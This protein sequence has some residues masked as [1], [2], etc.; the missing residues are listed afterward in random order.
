MSKPI[1]GF[2]TPVFSARSCSD[3]KTHSQQRW[4]IIVLLFAFTV[5]VHPCLA[6][7][8]LADFDV[9][10]FKWNTGETASD[11]ALGISAS[12]A[13]VLEGGLNLM[14]YG[15]TTPVYITEGPVNGAL[16]YF[17]YVDAANWT[18]ANGD[19]NDLGVSFNSLG[20][21]VY[22]KVDGSGNLEVISAPDFSAGIVLFATSVSL[23]PNK[24]FFFEILNGIVYLFY[25]GTLLVEHPLGAAGG[26]A[27]PASLGDDFVISVTTSAGGDTGSAT[28]NNLAR[29]PKLRVTWFPRVLEP[30]LNQV[31][32]SMGRD[33]LDTSETVD[34]A[35]YLT[36][37]GSSSADNVQ[38]QLVPPLGVGI[39]L[40]GAASQDYGSI[41]SGASTV[42][43]FRVTTAATPVGVHELTLNVTGGLSQTLTTSVPVWDLGATITNLPTGEA[44]ITGDSPYAEHTVDITAPEQIID[45]DEPYTF[46]LTQLDHRVVQSEP[47]Y[48]LHWGDPKVGDLDFVAKSMAEKQTT[49]TLEVEVNTRSGSPVPG[50]IIEVES[51]S[52]T[53]EFNYTGGDGKITFSGLEV[54]DNPHTVTIKPPAFLAGVYGT[55]T[56]S[57]SPEPGSWRVVATYPDIPASSAPGGNK[58]PGNAQ[59]QN[60]G[61]GAGTPAPARPAGGGKLKKG[62][63]AASGLLTAIGTGLIDLAASPSGPGAVAASVI[64]AGLLGGG[65]AVAADPDDQD[66]FYIGQTATPPVDPDE[67]T[68]EESVEITTSISPAIGPRQES[69]IM[70]NYT[71]TRITDLDTYTSSGSESLTFDFFLPLTLQT[72]A[73][74]FTPGDILDVWV[75]P[76]TAASEA[77]SG[78][79]VIVNLIA[80]SAD[81]AT[82]Y[83]QILL[84]DDGQGADSTA[85]DGTYSG[86]VDTTG[87]QDGLRLLAHA[88]RTGFF[89][90]TIPAAFGYE[91]LDLEAILFSDDFESGDTSMWSASSP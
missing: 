76:T 8:T 14:L 49:F 70:T 26:V 81:G 6:V 83:T 32:V 84:Q 42:R 71:Y 36:N 15:Q 55:G 47:F 33:V 20:D 7:L 13:P 29:D 46:V 17:G 4:T 64:G 24:A 62:R 10:A 87:W 79:D 51:A 73:D 78:A 66:L 40:A 74:H 80:L 37:I 19:G 85:N 30:H 28:I 12:P 38:V 9:A 88:S 57:I 77:L 18:P 86:L 11:T 90:E 27:D 72:S 50:A 61:Q 65:A 59:G 5:V 16:V 52:G 45:P 43:L 60:G 31:W 1:K 22:V 75:T 3:P 69:T 25:D 2:D 82:L 91:Y 56:K 89:E 34:L 39:S 44:T 54:A 58:P 23:D 68:T 63:S 35:L 48:G 21:R 67:L 41:P 53:W